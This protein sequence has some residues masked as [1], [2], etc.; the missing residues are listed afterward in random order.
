MDH[1]TA[2]FLYAPADAAAEMAACL[3]R[4]LD[5]TADERT[6]ERAREALVLWYQMTE[7]PAVGAGV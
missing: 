2:D 3:A 7:R 6:M 4:F 1:P 5:A